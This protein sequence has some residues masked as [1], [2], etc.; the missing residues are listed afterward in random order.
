VL[1][2]SA[3]IGFFLTFWTEAIRASRHHLLALI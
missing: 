1:N 2:R 3:D